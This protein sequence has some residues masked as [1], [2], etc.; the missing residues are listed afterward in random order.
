MTGSGAVNN[1][2]TMEPREL[3]NFI[4]VAVMIGRP[5]SEV[6]SGRRRTGK[7]GD[8]ERGTPN[9]RIRNGGLD[10]REFERVQKKTQVRLLRF[11][12]G[13]EDG[14]NSML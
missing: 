11:D 13:G 4:D 5:C 9:A 1:R 10:W 2:S 14:R 12:R 8:Y 7:N 3:R 6:R